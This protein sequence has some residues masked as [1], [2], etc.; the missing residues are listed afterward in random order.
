MEL[1]SGNLKKQIVA[2]KKYG[3]SLEK[4]QSLTQTEKTSL[5]DKYFRKQKI[6]SGMKENMVSKNIRLTNY[7]TYRFQTEVGDIGSII[8]TKGTKLSEVEKFRDNYL[9]KHGIK[10][11][12]QRK[13]ITTSFL[14]V[15]N[16]K[17]I[18]F[19]GMSYQIYVQRMKD[20][21]DASDPAVYTSNLQEAKKIRNQKIKN[22]P[23][24]NGEI[25]NI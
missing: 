14:S 16:E 5:K 15:K 3:L 10:K 4:Y 23:A 2:A 22:N 21:K 6:K 8:F 1:N 19:N 17:H 11:S 24:S 25:K 13:K 12:K 9:A 7:N 18:K 20:G